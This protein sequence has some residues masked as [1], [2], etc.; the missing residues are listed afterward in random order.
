MKPPEEAEIAGS[1]SSR[2]DADETVWKYSGLGV[3]HILDFF[4]YY[5]IS[6]PLN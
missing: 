6:F 2:R 5:S 1:G 3:G 4:L